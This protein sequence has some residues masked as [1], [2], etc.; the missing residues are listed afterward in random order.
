MNCSTIVMY[1][2]F[3]YTNLAVARD[4]SSALMFDYNFF[5][6]SYVYSD[7]RNVCWSLGSEEAK[8]A[9]QSIYGAFDE[10]EIIIDAIACELSSLIIACQRKVFPNWAN[11]GV[12]KVKDDRLLAAVERLLEV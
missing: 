2:D 7:I 1:T 3:Y 9:F 8:E 11:D 5:Y 4:G 12:E 6:K 10:R